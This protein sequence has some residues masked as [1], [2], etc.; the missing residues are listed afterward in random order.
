MYFDRRELLKIG[1]AS[2]AGLALSGFD[3]PFL[4]FKP[5]LADAISENAWCFGVMADTQWK[6]SDDADEAASTCALRII[7]AL[8][9]IEITNIPF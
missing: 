4:P 3:L 9:D 2:A 1:G 8:R 6:G 7:H 5:A